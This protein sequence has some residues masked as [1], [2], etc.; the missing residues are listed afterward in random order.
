LIALVLGPLTLLA[1]I[2]LASDIKMAYALTFPFHVFSAM[3]IGPGAAHVLS[4]V[5]PSRRAT[6]AAVYTTIEVFLGLAMGPYTIGFLSDEF[7]T[8]GY[9]SAASL[10]RGMVLA[11]LVSIPAAI[12]LVVAISAMKKTKADPA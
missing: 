1:I 5:V 2:Y 7:A 9:S 11:L 3:W 4:V 8:R 6:A 10:E 12:S